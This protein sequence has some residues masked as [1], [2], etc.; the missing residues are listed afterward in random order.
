MKQ[1]ASKFLA[2]QSIQVI[3]L[4][5]QTSKKTSLFTVVQLYFDFID[6]EILTFEEIVKK[7]QNVFKQVPSYSA[8]VAMNKYCINNTQV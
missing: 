2:K 4:V 5:Q 7:S 1:L 3:H 6:Q 8:Q